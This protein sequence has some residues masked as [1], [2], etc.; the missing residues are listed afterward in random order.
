M[1]IIKYNELFEADLKAKIDELNN[2]LSSLGANMQSTFKLAKDSSKILSEQ[3]KAQTIA[4]EKNNIALTEKTKIETQ[5]TIASKNLKIAEQNRIDLLKTIEKLEASARQNYEAKKKSTIGLTEAEKERYKIEQ[6]LIQSQT[7]QAV[8]NAKL[9]VQLQEQKK[10][11]KEAAKESLGLTGAYTKQ[12]RQ[13]REMKNRYKDLVAEGK[14]SEKGTVNLKKRIDELDTTVKKTSFDVGDFQKNVGNYPQLDKLI[15]KLDELK[16][17]EKQL[18]TEIKQNAIGFNANRDA[19]KGVSNSLNTTTQNVNRQQIGFKSLENELKSVQKEINKTE[20]EV[21]SFDT[22]TSQTGVASLKFGSILKELFAFAGIS[23]GLDKLKEFGKDIIN[24]IQSTSDKF[25]AMMKGMSSSYDSFIMTI[26]RGD[27]SN[28]ISNMQTAYEKGEQLA[29]TLDSLFELSLSNK[30]IESQYAEELYKLKNIYDDTSNSATARMTALEKT[31]ELE[32][33]IAKEQK[34]TAQQTYEAAKQNLDITSK[35]SDVEV[36]YYVKHF[37]NNLQALEQAKEYEKIKKK[38]SE[39]TEILYKV[40]NNIRDLQVKNVNKAKKELLNYSDEQIKIYEYLLRNE[41]LYQE[42]TNDEKVKG[43]VEARIALTEANDAEARIDSEFARKRGQIKRKLIKEEIKIQLS[44]YEQLK[45]EIELLDKQLQEEVTTNNENKN[46][47]ALILNQKIELLNK[48]EL[49]INLLKNLTESKKLDFKATEEQELVYRNLRLETEKLNKSL[50]DQ[51]K[52]FFEKSKGMDEVYKSFDEFSEKQLTAR[53]KELLDT[54]QYYDNL[55]KLADGN[56]A[57]IT[58]LKENQ[59]TDEDAINKKYNSIQLNE[60]IE[61]AEIA[62]NAARDMANQI[63]DAKIEALDYEID[64]RRKRQEEIQNLIDQENKKKEA[65]AAYSTK[66]LK[67]Q[68]AQEKAEEK[69]ALEEKRKIQKA[70][71][72]INDAAT[73]SNITLAVAKIFAANAEIPLV[74][75]VAAISS[76]GLMMAS[77]IASKIMAKKA[78]SSYADGTEFVE[79]N[80]N[81]KGTDTIPAMIDEGERIIDK[82]TNSKIPRN[83]K[84]KDLPTLLNAGISYFNAMQGNK[85]TSMYVNDFSKLEAIQNNTLD[86]Q[87]RTNSL[88]GKFIFVSGDGKTI[89][90][91]NGNIKT[92]V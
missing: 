23:F 85:L 15:I 9:N 78:V 82:R 33:K 87:K 74:G 69:K 63:A 68:L 90:D 92:H 35:M 65:G 64:E 3:I 43:L 58:L 53:D 19:Q 29:N 54:K 59:K 80:G 24:S 67:A 47:T 51:T 8:E 21:K 52:E 45:K 37:A 39:S 77:F 84:N 86:E 40:D 46:S 71:Q 5:L 88:L 49:E 18:T 28:L 89:I 32:K 16:N 61:A 13:L 48:I 50:S 55:L 27:W 22:Q 26:N 20:K 2:S 60:G 41:K 75:V 31:L 4:E 34:I 17:K 83:I 72:L 1:D 56:A 76:I 38:A 14:E 10:A 44:A 30:L 91:I 57:A 36:L 7:Q 81:K 42:N 25:E 70:Q 66:T 62:V 73:L 6:K 11:N 12:E 79:L